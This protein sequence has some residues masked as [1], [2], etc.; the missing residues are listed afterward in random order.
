MAKQLPRGVRNNNPG[1][2]DYNPA[3]KWQGRLPQDK[4]IE[5]RFERFES[6]E[7]GIRALAR[8]LITYQDRH[9][10][11]TVAEY[12]ARYAPTVENDTSAYVR[13]VA[14]DLGVDPD[15]QIDV[16]EYPTMRALV[17]AIIAHENAGYAYP[18][19]VVD[20]G[21]ALAGVLPAGRTVAVAKPAPSPWLDPG[22]IATTATGVGGA[23]V[24]GKAVIDA[25]AE[26]QQ[27]AVPVLG[28]WAPVFGAV[29]LF[30]GLAVIGWRVLQR[31]RRGEA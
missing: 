8:L 24:A 28:E 21:L 22:V 27:A 16:H 26:A 11:D 29:I 5:D 18:D 3:N 2:I 4:A 7:M 1:N 12:L 9:G 19:A 15:E 23:I 13:R 14:D 17:V 20:K 6:P 10:L 25:A 31:R 30:G